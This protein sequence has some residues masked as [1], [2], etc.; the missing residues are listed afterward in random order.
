MIENASVESEHQ[1][2]TDI[3]LLISDY[4]FG[5]IKQRSTTDVLDFVNNVNGICDW[6]TAIDR[7][8]FLK[9]L[10]TALT[11]SYWSASRIKLYMRPL[12][13]MSGIDQNN[14]WVMLSLQESKSSQSRLVREINSRKGLLI[15]STF[16]ETHDSYIYI[17]DAA[18]TGRTLAKY[19]VRIGYEL[20][21]LS[22]K[23]RKLVVWHLTEYTSETYS[24][25]N[26]SL[27]LLN[28]L[29]VDVQFKRV[30][31]LGNKT[32]EGK[33]LGT[34][35]PSTAC[36]DSQ[37]VQRYLKSRP[38][39]IAMKDN[40]DLWR[41]PEADFVDGLFAS[42]DERHVVEKALLEV[43]CYLYL[44]T[45]Q[46]KFRPLGYFA[47][48]KDVSFGFGSMFCTC[49]NSANTTPVAMWWGNP[50]LPKNNPLS[51]WSP[52]LPRIV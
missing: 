46:P 2:A 3:S 35:L 45:K 39:L 10:R 20:S 47:S 38:A 6:M 33:K 1:I 37:I 48:N 52:L 22:K 5:D 15:S 32:E 30:E 36:A 11:N 49:H 50:D 31:D 4:R 7:R 14:E 41:D 16:L 28:N 29:K 43:G 44:R 27:L 12:F 13:Q 25:I 19:L 21:M 9:G 17:D 26:G 23:T 34:L 18:Y 51:L 8:Y 42:K 40:P 24:Q